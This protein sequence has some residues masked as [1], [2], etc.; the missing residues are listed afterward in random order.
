MARIL[1]IEDD[2]QVRAMLKQMLEVAGHEVTEAPD[3]E[4]AIQLQK[5]NPANLVIT[6]IIMPVKEGL[7]TIMDLR[8]AFPALKIIAISG[9]GQLGPDGYLKSAQILGADRIFPKPLEMKTVLDTV[10]ELLKEG[11][12]EISETPPTEI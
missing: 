9:G 2:D 11:E 12:S 7:E 1:V 5:Q 10:Q 6:D 4:A 3:G 8:K